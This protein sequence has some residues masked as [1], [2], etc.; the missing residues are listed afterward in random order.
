MSMMVCS[1]TPAF[2]IQKIYLLKQQIY[3]W[4]EIHF[5]G[6]V[7]K[8]EPSLV[9][10]WG[11]LFPD[12]MEKSDSFKSS[13]SGSMERL[14]QVFY[15]FIYFLAF[16]LDSSFNSC[17]IFVWIKVHCRHYSGIL[18]FCSLVFKGQ[19]KEKK[20]VQ[21][22]DIKWSLRPS[23]KSKVLEIKCR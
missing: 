15:L 13:S 17:S 10:L 11:K 22:C 3:Q 5:R 7:R 12:W 4:G 6:R 20:W 21:Q 14:F 18:G 8:A 9:E 23:N 19:K 1:S 16:C 2:K